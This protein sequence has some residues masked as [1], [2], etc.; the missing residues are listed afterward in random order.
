MRRRLLALGAALA[1]LMPAGASALEYWDAGHEIRCAG[2]R[3][4]C[5]LLQAVMMGSF[6][7]ADP[8]DAVIRRVLACAY[9]MLCGIT[10]EDVAH[11]AGEFGEAEAD[12][13]ERWYV[14]LANCLRAEID[15]QGLPESR[16]EPARRVLLLFLEDAPGEAAQREAIRREMTPEALALLAEASGAPEA[17]VAWLVGM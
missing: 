5:R 6:D 16:L 8:E 11:C 10:D 12:V 2:D 4:G 1:L 3:A 15:G 17:F 9:P 14:A 13:R 7:G